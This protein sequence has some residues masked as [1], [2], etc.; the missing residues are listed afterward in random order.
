MGGIIESHPDHRQI[1]MEHGPTYEIHSRSMSA[2]AMLGIAI[3]LMGIGL[4][5]GI[6]SIRGDVGNNQA[7]GP[8]TITITQQGTFD[9]T[10][11]NVAA[12][13]TVT[14]TNANANP[15]VV[16]STD[17]SRVL[18]PAKVIFSTPVTVTIPSSANGV[19]TYTSET[20]P[21]S[22]T[23]TFTVSTATPIPFGTTTSTPGSASS[24]TPI[25]FGQT[26]SNY[27]IPIPFGRPSSATSS[28]GSTVSSTSSSSSQTNTTSSASSAGTTS[29]VTITGTSSS[30]GT[31][32]VSVLDSG[33]RTQLGGGVTTGGGYRGASAYTQP[34]YTAPA[35]LPVNPYTVG[36]ATTQ[37]A[38]AAQ[39]QSAQKNVATTANGLHSG[40]PLQQLSQHRPKSVSGTGP[41]NMLLLFLPALLGVMM[42]Y[43]RKMKVGI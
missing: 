26:A 2:A 11:V 7:A 25:P 6:G 27:E 23:L 40:A 12:G 29:S 39:N 10:S 36:T 13:Q 35:A 32:T 38:T 4:Y 15:Q 37:A 43:G 14:I 5:V 1:H 20:L 22:Q 42:L 33:G 30:A 41:E 3:V 9:P 31:V 17:P 34:N 18:F 21:T 8:V 28:A 16:K 24:D 19:Y